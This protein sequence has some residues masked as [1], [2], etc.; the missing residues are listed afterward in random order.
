MSDLEFNVYHQEAMCD[1]DMP[2]VF[3]YFTKVSL[4][5]SYLP[6]SFPPSFSLVLFPLC[7]AFVSR[8][9]ALCDEETGGLDAKDPNRP[10]F[11]LQELRDVLHERN[12]LKAKVF[13]LQEELA[14]YRR[15]SQ[16]QIFQSDETNSYDSIITAKLLIIMMVCDYDGLCFAVMNQKMRSLL[17]VHL[18][19][20]N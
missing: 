10:R 20:Q 13:L 2:A 3:Q 6:S 14:Y 4:L 9:E 15:Y 17:P 19:H 5:P 16:A 7:H 11:T 1:E 12:E 18:P 8:Q